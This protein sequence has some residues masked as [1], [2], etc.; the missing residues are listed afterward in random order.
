MI[1]GLLNRSVPLP[2][3]CC[4]DMRMYTFPP[5]VGGSM[6]TFTAITPWVRVDPMGPDRA[7]QQLWSQWPVGP[8]FRP[9]VLTGWRWVSFHSRWGW[10]V[11]HVEGVPGTSEGE[12]E[13]RGRG[14]ADQ[15]GPAGSKGE[16]VCRLGPALGSSGRRRCF[17]WGWRVWT[18]ARSHTGGGC[19][20]INVVFFHPDTAWAGRAAGAFPG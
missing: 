10:P 12:R 2:H 4:P 7:E 19:R 11:V 16:S 6:M 17:W 14:G 15:P 3:F 1:T 18:S 13:T 8:P 20:R 9:F 5:T